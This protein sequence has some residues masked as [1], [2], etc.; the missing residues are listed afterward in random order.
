MEKHTIKSMKSWSAKD[1]VKSRAKRGKGTSAPDKKT[2]DI[3]KRLFK[4]AQGSKGKV[5]TLILG[6]TPEIRDLALSLNSETVAVDISPRLLLALTNVMKYKDDEN[7][8]F[9]VGDWLKLHK[10]LDKN[11]FD[12]V[13][14]DISINNLP[15][16]LWDDFFK[17]LSY[18]MKKNAYYIPRHMVFN[19]PVETRTCEEVIEEFRENNNSVFEMIADLALGTDVVREGYDHKKKSMSWIPLKKYD[20]KMRKFLDKEEYLFFANMLK[21][22]K[23]LTTV[24]ISEKEF[25]KKISKYFDLKARKAVGTIGNTYRL[26]VYVF[27]NKKNM[28]SN[29]FRRLRK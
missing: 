13:L 27:K 24:I 10:F 15:Y 26:P 11:S 5:R 1:N 17:S 9:M 20:K 6:A 18:V 2:L 8:K 28:F 12:I 4:I 7:N 25:L 22:G 23:D 21:H 14:S 16:D 29:I 3:E 19:Y